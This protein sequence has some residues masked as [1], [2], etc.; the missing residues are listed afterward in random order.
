MRA[1]PKMPVAN[2]LTRS[3]SVVVPSGKFRTETPASSARIAPS[4]AA[5]RLCTSPRSTKIAPRVAAAE[6][7]T[8]QLATSR[9]ASAVHAILDPMTIGSR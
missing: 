7:I 4:S 3:P 9:L 6:P 5:A 8:G 1:A 2:G